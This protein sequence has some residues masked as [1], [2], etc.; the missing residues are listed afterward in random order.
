MLLCTLLALLLACLSV[1]AQQDAR[2]VAPSRR[3]S[4]DAW[5]RY[6]DTD[7][8]LWW[9]QRRERALR[10]DPWRWWRRER[11]RYHRNIPDYDSRP[12]KHRDLAPVPPV[13][14]GILPP[15]FDDSG[16]VDE[17]QDFYVS[18]PSRTTIYR[19]TQSASASAS[20]P[21]SITSKAYPSTS[22]S[23]APSTTAPY[24]PSS[25]RATPSYATI[26][27]VSEAET[28]TTVYATKRRLRALENSARAAT[29]RLSIWVSGTAVLLGL[30][31]LGL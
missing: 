10:Q 28:T 14:P 29:S 19:P 18:L 3:T 31:L 26:V 20:A 4:N 9:R 8:D 1:R 25:I 27:T 17:D 30:L 6:D 13:A 7:W 22:S 12:R 5:W 24:A 16:L 23:A 21:A 2:P 11:D 15:I